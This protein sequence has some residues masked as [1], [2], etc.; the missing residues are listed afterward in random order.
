MSDGKRFWDGQHS[1]RVKDFR[2]TNYVTTRKHGVIPGCVPAVDVFIERT[3]EH[4]Q[5]YTQLAA[6][7]YI[8]DM[9]TMDYKEFINQPIEKAAP[10]FRNL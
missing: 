8:R 4:A 5:R 10:T 9:W 6:A 1:W 7:R 2:S 3:P